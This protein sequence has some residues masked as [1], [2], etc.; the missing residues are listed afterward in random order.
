M[1][2]YSQNVGLQRYNRF[3]VA[4]VL[5]RT[6]FMQKKRDNEEIVR[7]VIPVDLAVALI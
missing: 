3:F 6:L 5:F 4:K 2:V 7:R 1:L